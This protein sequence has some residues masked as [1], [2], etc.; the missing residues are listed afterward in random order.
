MAQHYVPRFYLRPF[1]SD[2]DESQVFSMSKDHTIHD[3]TSPI[4]K[5]CAKKNYNTPEQEREQDNLEKKHSKILR[6]FVNTPNSE[7]FY[8]SREFVESVSFLMGNNIYIRDSFTKTLRATLEKELGPELSADIS[9]NIGYRGQLKSSIAFAD[10]VFE[11]FQSWQFVRHKI[12]TNDKIFITSDNPVNIFNSKNVFTTYETIIQLKNV[13]INFGNESR[14]VS[15]NRTSRDVEINFTLDSVSFGQDVVMIFPVTPSVCLLAFSDSQTHARHME[16]T[17]NN[18]RFVGFTNITTLS[19]CNK[20][21]YSHAKLRLEETK[22][23]I[24]SFLDYFVRHR[25]NPSFESC[26]R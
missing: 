4:S 9:I 2:S 17:K 19:Q 3:K 24:R 21:A 5:I 11:E 10:C 6:G 8:G 14:H 22:K 25:I 23:N 15:E 13:N 18:F 26:I 7:T 12:D 16:M 1:A 20:V